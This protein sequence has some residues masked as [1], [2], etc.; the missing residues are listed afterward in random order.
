MKFIK[1]ILLFE[2]ETSGANPDKDVVL[3]IGALLLD[4]DNLLEKGFY[5]TYIRNSLIEA[6]LKEQAKIAHTSFEN[7]QMGVKPLEFI[8]LFSSQFSGPL[9]LAMPSVSRLLFLKNTFKKQAVPFPYDLN[10]IDLWTMQYMFSVKRG[11]RKMPTLNTLAE[12][13]HMTITNPYNAFERAKTHAAIFRKLC[14]EF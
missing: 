5:H 1:D 10:I 4:K 3:Q 13:F 14:V 2:V 11:L 12:D 6:T 7:L 9:T 8:K